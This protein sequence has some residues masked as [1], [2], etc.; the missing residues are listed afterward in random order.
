MKIL[1]QVIISTENA[2]SW[3]NILASILG[4]QIFS[5][6]NFSS[7]APGLGN[8]FTLRRSSQEKQSVLPLHRESS[9]NHIRILNYCGLKEYLETANFKVEALVGAGYFHLPSILGRFDP[10]HAHFLTIKA[11]KSE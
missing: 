10:I 4:W 7:L 8:P 1:G 9:W 11:R 6:T 2:S 5:L 3:C